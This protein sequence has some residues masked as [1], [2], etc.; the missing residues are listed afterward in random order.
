[1]STTTTTPVST[2]KPVRLIALILMIAGALLVVAGGA[3]WA[4]VQS[5]LVAENITIPDD[6]M[7]F[8]G[9]QVNGP[10]DAYVQAELPLGPL[11]SR[12]LPDDDSTSGPRTE[13]SP[14]L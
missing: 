7:A 14:Y 9:K 12:Q 13:A 2:A 3:T 8:Q 1:M 4:V 5:N 10:L 11:G 6:A